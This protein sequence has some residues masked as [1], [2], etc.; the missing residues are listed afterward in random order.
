MRP[1]RAEEV[2]EV[3]SLR[4]SP[5]EKRQLQLAAAA[6]FQRVSEFARDAI[7]TAAA[8]SLEGDEGDINPV[9]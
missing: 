8:E 9:L 2:S 6:N 1:L 4:V 3:I 7:V 5:E